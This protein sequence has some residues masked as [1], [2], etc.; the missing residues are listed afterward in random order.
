M[1]WIGDSAVMT[2]LGLKALER[3]TRTQGVMTL[4]PSCGEWQGQGLLAANGNKEEI[5]KEN[6]ERKRNLASNN[7]WIRQWIEEDQDESLGRLH[8]RLY[9]S[10]ADFKVQL[11]SETL[12][13]LLLVMSHTR[14][15]ILVWRQW[16][17]LL[18]NYNNKSGSKLTQCSH[19]VS[20]WL[21]T[22]YS[23]SHHHIVS[24]Q[25]AVHDIHGL[26]TV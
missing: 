7:R 22:T 11:E 20:P 2:S 5:G 21:I 25:E 3:M 17:S 18:Y 13:Q 8:W 4:G 24:V 9:T 16:Q 14:T 1:W 10:K 19:A 6:K 23:R 26:Y 15:G 12:I